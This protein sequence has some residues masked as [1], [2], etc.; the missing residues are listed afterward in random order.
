MSKIDA[1]EHA[2]YCTCI[3]II[4]I[5]LFFPFYLKETCEHVLIT[6]MYAV[7]CVYM[8][9]WVI[10]FSS[11]SRVLDNGSK[12]QAGVFPFFSCVFS[13]SNIH[14]QMCITAIIVVLQT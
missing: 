14:E 5:S 10:S 3:C 9:L 7:A 12:M 1:Y 11:T 6:F 8:C 13:V 2:Y 4:V